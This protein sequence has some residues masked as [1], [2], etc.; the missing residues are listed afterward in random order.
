[1]RTERIK[2]KNDDGIEL[3]ARLENPPGKKPS[4][5]AIFAHCF[6]C[7]KNIRAAT[8]ISRGLTMA[9]YGV[10][11][12]DFTGLGQSKGD[13]AST[14][15]TSNLNDLESAARFLE[16]NYLAPSLI[17]GHSLG[18]TAVLH[19]G[20]A[21]ESVK[22]ICT[23][24]APFEA[25]HVVHLL[26]DKKSEIQEKGRAE[27]SIGGRPFEIGKTFLDDITKH[28]TEELLSGMKKAL[29][30]MHSPQDSIVEI[31]N[32]AKIYTAA[33]HPK[34]FVS[35]DGADHLLSNSEDASYA[36]SVIGVWAKRY[37]K[38]QEIEPLETTQEVA[39]QLGSDGFT[40][41]IVAGDHRFLADEPKDVG[42]N[43][44]G[45]SPYQLLNASLGACTA[46]TLKMYAERKEWNLKEVIVHLS[47]EKRHVNDS[48]NPEK[49]SSKIEL[50]ERSIELKGDLSEEQRSKLLEI[51]N[52]CPVHRTLTESEVKVSTK[53]LDE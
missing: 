43:D 12:F 29:L 23:I 18:G 6:T 9:G 52:K 25:E 33:F 22:A 45:P 7:G 10:L 14:N 24:G 32:A 41:E 30:V 19:A 35:L 5:Y 39:V 36:A 4:A 13:F 53:L 2:F 46:M 42:G 16:K 49:K 11:R 26:G 15:F 28:S 8:M 50:F 31:A 17:I 47:H 40:T 3:S 34:S 21:L 38:P 51:A 20:A 44:S 48:A 27:V 1:V 37:V